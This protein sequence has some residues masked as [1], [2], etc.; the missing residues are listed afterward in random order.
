MA[1]ITLMRKFN[2]PSPINPHSC[3]AAALRS[4][5]PLRLENSRTNFLSEPNTWT[6]TG[7]GAMSYFQLSESENSHRS[8]P[9]RPCVF[10]VF[11]R[12]NKM[13][14]LHESDM[15]GQAVITLLHW[16]ENLFSEC[17]FFLCTSGE[18]LISWWQLGLIVRVGKVGRFHDWELGISNLVICSILTPHR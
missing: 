13:W 12:Q 14:W 5:S 18:V 17:N 7:S 8:V 6:S 2:R 10:A 16:S 1:S 15:S 3:L 11:P 9:S 4:A